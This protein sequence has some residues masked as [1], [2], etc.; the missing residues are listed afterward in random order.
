MSEPIVAQITLRSANSIKNQ[1]EVES[2]AAALTAAL[3][4]KQSHAGT[5]LKL[6]VQL[7]EAQSKASSATDESLKCSKLPFTQVRALPSLGGKGRYHLPT[8]RRERA[9]PHSPQQQPF[10][11]DILMVNE[12]WCLLMHP[13]GP[14]GQLLAGSL[15]H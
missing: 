7:G 11:H 8:R 4:L 12:S 9:V 14:E 2:L 10:K 1:D 3:K 5:A 6:A 15:C 13:A